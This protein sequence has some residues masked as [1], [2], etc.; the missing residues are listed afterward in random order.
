MTHASLWTVFALGLLAGCPAADS[1]NGPVPTTDLPPATA[2]AATATATATA[3]A[4]N[5]TAAP[6]G[7]AGR[8]VGSWES[9]SCGERKYARWLTLK[10]DGRVIG[11]DRVSPC[12]PKVA[13]VW[14][15]IVPWKGQYGAQGDTARL[16]VSSDAGGPAKTIKLPTGLRWDTASNAPAEGD[17]VYRKRTLVLKRPN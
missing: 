13:C 1:P 3:P 8:W 6:A 5:T 17:C 15:G 11:Q 14:S 12:P 2:T 9:P 7:D 4:P 16:T 10:P